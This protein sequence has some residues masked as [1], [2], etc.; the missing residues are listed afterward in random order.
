MP[1][2]PSSLELD[3]T[4]E[5]EEDSSDEDD[6]SDEEDEVAELDRIISELEDSTDELE[7]SGSELEEL[8]SSEELDETIY[9]KELIYTKKAR[10]QKPGIKQL[11]RLNKQISSGFCL[12]RPSWGAGR[13]ETCRTWRQIPRVFPC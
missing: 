5:E 4:S 3:S 10:T 1:T 6:S 13:K 7:D 2:G 8:N 12:R 11:E 9:N